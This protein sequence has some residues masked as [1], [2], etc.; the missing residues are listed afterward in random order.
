M[1][2]KNTKIHKKVRIY[3]RAFSSVYKKMTFHSRIVFLLK[4]ALPSITALFLGVVVLIPQIDEKIKNIKIDIPSIDTTDKISFTMDNGN[5]YG[6]GEDGA[7]FSLNLE[8]FKEDREN[9][10]MLFS[11]ITA[12]IFLKDGSWIN[13]S[14]DKGNYI[15]KD[16]LFFMNGNIVITDS[17]DNKV[18]TDEAIVNIDD[19]SVSGDKP[20][21]AFT[22]FGQINGQ[23]FN[24]KQN[25]KYSFFGKVSGNIDTAKIEKQ[26]K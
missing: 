14:T 17:D 25:E 19:M 24:F 11:K 1:V 20:I 23:G 26:H 15:K 5:F 2:K 18:Y 10:V 9:M 22:N 6:Q 21:R 4:I 3:K 12:K 16:N 8:N 13:V 7:V